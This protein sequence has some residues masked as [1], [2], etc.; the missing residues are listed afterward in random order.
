MYIP[1]FYHDVESD[2]YKIV[3]AVN[4]RTCEEGLCVINQLGLMIVKDNGD[5]YS[6]D[7]LI[8]WNNPGEISKYIGDYL[9]IEEA[10]SL[11]K[12]T[13]VLLSNLSKLTGISLA[14]SFYLSENYKYIPWES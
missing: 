7:K 13:H 12:N 6:S 4:L 10:K 1:I 9:E 2:K 8:T 14:K 5:Y 11:S 3:E